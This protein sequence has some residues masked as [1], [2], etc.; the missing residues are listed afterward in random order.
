MA[1]KKR[2]TIPTANYLPQ[3]RIRFQLQLVA[4]TEKES[5]ILPTYLFLLLP[6]PFSE[7]HQKEMQL[8]S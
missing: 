5:M 6:S 8:F 2:K 4:E 1:V 7:R 3:T